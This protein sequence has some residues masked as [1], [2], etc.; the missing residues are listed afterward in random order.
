MLFYLSHVQ[1]VFT[2]GSIKRAV[3]VANDPIF[4]G[5][6]FNC[7]NRGF[8]LLTFEWIDH[9]RYRYRNRYRYRPYY[10]PS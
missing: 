4:D 1:I 8:Y 9:D 2:A 6:I 10:G 5:V 3:I 7:H